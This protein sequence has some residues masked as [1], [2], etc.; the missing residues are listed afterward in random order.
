MSW[1]PALLFM[2]KKDF[3]SSQKEL[4][5]LI[6]YRIQSETNSKIFWIICP[7]LPGTH[8]ML[9]HKW[10]N[11]PLEKS[12]TGVWNLI[13]WKTF[14]QKLSIQ[15]TFNRFYLHKNGWFVHWHKFQTKLKQKLF[16]EKIIIGCER[17]KH[18]CIILSKS[19]TAI[20]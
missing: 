19:C 6:Q 15:N 9:A 17:K 10:K 18:R 7:R 16:V 11:S 12:V 20:T 4:D 14:T 13:V 8:K 3:F 5:E 2:S 1:N